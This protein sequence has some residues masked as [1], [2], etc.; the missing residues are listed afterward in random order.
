MKYLVLAV[1]VLC[2][3]VP[4]FAAEIASEKGEMEKSMEIAR[5]I[6]DSS[7]VEANLI[8]ELLPQAGQ[9]MSA[10]GQAL[11]SSLTSGADQGVASCQ[12]LL[13]W[14]HENGIQVKKSDDLATAFYEK[15][16]EKG[17][18]RACFRLGVLLF[19][20][21][22]KKGLLTPASSTT[23]P[24]M[25]EALKWL[26]KGAER[27]DLSSR[28]T[29]GM[30]LLEGRGLGKD[31]VQA[32]AWMKLAA[33]QE[34]LPTDPVQMSGEKFRDALK[35]VA[36]DLSSQDLKKAEKLLETLKKIAPPCSPIK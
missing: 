17:D 29:L 32:W 6:N 19:A 8:T 24:N 13:G 10:S 36:D 21:D 15:A 4:A 28:F 30:I 9:E 3:G 18:L 2:L 35:T 27:G 14:L 26:R 11:L 5:A 25:E 31:S 23:S 22:A 1:F 7:P 12:Y 20:R 16:A 34:L 33:G